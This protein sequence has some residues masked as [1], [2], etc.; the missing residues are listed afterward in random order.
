M[1]V[2]RTN[3]N[4]RFH[5]AGAGVRVLRPDNIYNK[6]KISKKKIQKNI[7]FINIHLPL[8]APDKSDLK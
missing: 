4:R 8:H 1:N 6:V 3:Q 7:I 2:L 5:D